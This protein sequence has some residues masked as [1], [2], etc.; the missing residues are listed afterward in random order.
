MASQPVSRVSYDLA[1]EL[2]PHM[3]GRGYSATQFAAACQS[4]EP[5]RQ[6]CL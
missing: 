2:I 6:M 1:L 3:D 4:A 5:A